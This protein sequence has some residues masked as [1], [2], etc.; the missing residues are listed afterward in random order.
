MLG[1]LFAAGEIRK[2]YLFYTAASEAGFQ[3][4][5]GS[6]LAAQ[7]ARLH[8]VPAEFIAGDQNHRTTPDVD[9][10]TFLGNKIIP[11]G[12]TIWPLEAETV[13]WSLFATKP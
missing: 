2:L 5:C 6:L 8:G 1:A 10:S 7:L 3:A 9:V 11:A 4:I 13:S 12:V